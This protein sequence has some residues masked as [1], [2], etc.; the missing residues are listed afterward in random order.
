[1]NEQ[2]YINLG[3]EILEILITPKSD[4]QK[5]KAVYNRL[6]DFKY[7]IEENQ[8]TIIVKQFIDALLTVHISYLYNDYLREAFNNKLPYLRLIEVC[9]YSMFNPTLLICLF[10]ILELKSFPHY[11]K[12]LVEA[13][14]K[15]KPD[16]LNDPYIREILSYIIQNERYIEQIKGS[17]YHS[18]EEE[19]LRFKNPQKFS[20][21]IQ[22]YE[23]YEEQ[24]YRIQNKAIG[25]IGEIILYDLLKIKDNCYFVAR[26]IND[27]FGFDIYYTENDK[28][29]LI[30][31]K[32]TTYNREKDYFNISENEYQ[33]MLDCLN[34]DNVK[35]IIARVFLDTDLNLVSINK[36]TLIDEE[37]L[38]DMNNPNIHYKKKDS[39][40]EQV[41]PEKEKRIELI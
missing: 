17:N 21:E 20:S 23:N 29:F 5:N 9:K 16:M 19:L 13:I 30:E 1:M 36:L 14:T 22:P 6:K 34:K 12:G 32:T 2:D 4:I 8:E 24:L 35:Y 31:V 40:F 10:N 33:Q 25:N 28:E 7:Y 37:T 38:E 11:Y 15:Y 3:K 26:D 39:I 18:K 41:I 27:F